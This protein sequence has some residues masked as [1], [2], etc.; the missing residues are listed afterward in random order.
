MRIALGLALLFAIAA[1][2]GEE[3][4]APPPPPPPAVVVRRE[5][6]GQTGAGGAARAAHARRRTRVLPIAREGDGAACDKDA[7]SCDA[8]K[9]C[10]QVGNAWSC[11][12]CPERD[13]VRHEFKDRD[14]VADQTR[15]PFQSYIIAQK[16][17]EEEPEKKEEGP[18]K[19]QDQFVATNYSYLDLTLVG[20]VAQGTQ[21]KVLMM[22]RGNLGHIVHRGD[23]VGKEKAVVKDIGPGFVT[24]V[25]AADDDPKSPNRAPTERSVQLHPKGLQMTPRIC[26]AAATARRAPRS[27]RRPRNRR[28]GRPSSPLA[29]Q[30]RADRYALIDRKF[31]IS[32]A[33]RATIFFAARLTAGEASSGTQRPTSVH[34]ARSRDDHEP[35][36]LASRRRSHRDGHVSQRAEANNEVRAVTFTEDAG[37]TLVHVRGEQTPT[38][39]V[40]KLE[41]PSRVV[42]DL[43][44]ARLSESLRGHESASV[45]TPNTWAVSTIAAQQLDDG[46]T[47]VIVSL[48]RPGRY[49][50]KTDGNEVVIMVMPR[51]AAPKTANPAELEKARRKHKPPSKKRHD[52]VRSRPNKQHAPSRRRRPSRKRRSSARRISSARSSRGSRERRSGPCEDGSREGTDRSRPR[53]R[54]GK[55]PRRD[56]GDC[57]GNRGE[58]AG[59]GRDDRSSRPP[60]ATAEVAKR[61]ARRRSVKRSPRRPTHAKAQNER[62]RRSSPPRSAPRSRASARPMPRSAKP[63][64]RRPRREGERDRDARARR[65]ARTRSPRR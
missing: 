11:E 8:G 45:L 22:D 46:G 23:C 60:S 33:S 1:C 55:L 57:R 18:C 53:R 32:A 10:L 6:R 4:G 15:D 35:E 41:R 56:A 31:V 63:R 13:S 20:I 12:P 19:R 43:P 58:G 50:V 44:Q 48:A 24:F 5:A 52:S 40:Y 16:G 37:T 34:V 29:G 47:R 7:P 2:G 3:D 42:I 17:L 28:P 61:E 39:T 30:R 14:F 38:F 59:R 26:R 36:M 49:D 25:I 51:D 65:R 62:R 27:L 21:R 9:F 54:R 64:P